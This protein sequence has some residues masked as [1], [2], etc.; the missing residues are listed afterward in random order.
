[1]PVIGRMIIRVFD[2]SV[3]VDHPMVIFSQVKTFSE[4]RLTYFMV[5]DYD[6]GTIIFIA[7]HIPGKNI[8][9]TFYQPLRFQEDIHVCLQLLVF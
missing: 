7:I 2:Y 5:M 6:R 1:M 3:L 8:S 9:P 4:W